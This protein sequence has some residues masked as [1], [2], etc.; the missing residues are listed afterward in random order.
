MANK[1]K[2]NILL[3]SGNGYLTN[4]SSVAFLDLVSHIKDKYNVFA[5]VDRNGKL[6]NSLRK[7]NVKVIIK[8]QH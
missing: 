1:P 2:K 5:V 6:A 8:K 4:G 7:L 3:V